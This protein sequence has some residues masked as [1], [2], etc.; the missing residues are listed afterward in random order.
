MS[1]SFIKLKSHIMACV[2]DDAAPC[3]VCMFLACS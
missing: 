2:S 3:G 1:L